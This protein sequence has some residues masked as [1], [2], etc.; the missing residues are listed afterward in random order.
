MRIFAD[1]RVVFE[2]SK[3]D[4]PDNQ[5]VKMVQ[6]GLSRDPSLATNVM[7]QDDP[8]WQSFNDP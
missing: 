3:P 7:D 4:W 8:G 1:C 6:E 2:L 5:T